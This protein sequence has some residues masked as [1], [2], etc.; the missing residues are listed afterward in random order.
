M[1]HYY[2]LLSH[3]LSLWYTTIFY[4]STGFIYDTLLYI[5][6][7]Y[8]L[9]L[10]NWPFL[11]YSTI[12]YWPTGSLC[13]ALPSSP[14]PVA[15]SYVTLQFYTGPLAISLIHY[16]LLLSHWLSL[17]N[18]TIYFWPIGCLC[19]AL[20]SSFGPL[21]LSMLL[22]YLLLANWLSLWYTTIFS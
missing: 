10:P 7:H 14:G 1:V 15:P 16:N 21:A 6:T 19:G 8:Y 4:W 12:S 22:C 18:T 11:C 17:W 9:L 2:L 13:G 20:L 5:M 3:W